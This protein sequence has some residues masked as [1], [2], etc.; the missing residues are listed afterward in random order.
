MVLTHRMPGALWGQVKVQTQACAQ[1]VSDPPRPLCPTKHNTL[2]YPRKVTPL[3]VPSLFSNHH[4]CRIFVRAEVHR[5]S[6]DI[7]S[8]RAVEYLRDISGRRIWQ[9]PAAVCS[10]PATSDGII[11]TP[12]LRLTTYTPSYKSFPWSD[13]SSMLL[14]AIFVI[15]ST[16]IIIAGAKPNTDQGRGVKSGKTMKTLFHNRITDCAAGCRLQQW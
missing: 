7:C 4:I 12:E 14:I 6:A 10:N 8:L 2:R 5:R 13:A 15:T 16:I 3:T 11:C 9:F 1:Y